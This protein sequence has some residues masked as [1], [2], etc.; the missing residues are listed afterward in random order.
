[1]T[2]EPARNIMKTG[3]WADADCYRIACECHDS[4]HD[5]DVWIE[6][7][8]DPEVNDVTLTFYKEMYSPMWEQGFNRFREAFRI[9][10]TGTTR[11]AGTIILKKDVAQ[12]FVDTVQRSIDRL[13][14]KK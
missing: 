5:L 14:A 10:F 12:N 7:E 11:V 6:V 2:K 8:P 1:M 3:E 13:D 4:G 9:L